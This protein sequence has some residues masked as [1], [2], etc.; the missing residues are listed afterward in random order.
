MNEYTGVI[1]RIFFKK[2]DF[3]IGLLETDTEEI[4][5]TGNI[6]GIGKNE[7]LTI[8]GEWVKHHKYGEQLQVKEWERPMPKTRE[9]VIS[10]LSSGLIKGVG[11][12]RAETIVD[13]LGEQAIDIINRDGEIALDGIKG[14]G[15]KTAKGIAESIKNTFEVQEIVSQLTV[16]GISTNTTLKLYR[17]YG[18]STAETVL[19]NPYVMTEVDGVGFLKADEIARKIG[20]MPTSGYRIN[21]C[22]DYVLK[23]T[24]NS[25]GHSYVYESELISETL[26][27]LNHNS[28][29]EVS[30]DEVMQG[31][32]AL[33]D[34]LLVIEEEKVYPKY[35]FEYELGLAQKLSK[36]RGSRDGEAMTSL[37]KHIKS[38]QKK[39]SIILADKQREAIKLLMKEQILIL[40]GGPGTGKT[41]VVKAMI[42]IYKKIYPK[43]I[44]RLAAPTGRASRKLEESTGYEAMTIHRMIGYRQ[45][46]LPEY[47]HD[48]RL[49]GDLIVIDEMSMVD[50][51]LAYWLINAVENKS[52]ILFIGDTDQLPS[53]GPGNVLKDM[54]KSGLPTVELTDI[55]R[56][57]E[58]SQIVTNAHRINSGK[59]LLIDQTK[60]DFYFINQEDVNQIAQLILLSAMRFEQLGYTT[61]DILILSPMKK[62]HVGT[63]ILNEKLRDVLNPK[64]IH[65]KELILGK[66][67][68]REGDKVM[69]NKNNMDKDVFNGELGRIKKITKEFDDNN[70]LID[71]IICDFDGS[72][73][74]YLREDM[75]EIELGYAITIHK[76][77]GGEA[78]IVIMPITTHHHVMLARNLY[79]TGVT[80]AKE[81][82]VLIGTNQAMDI[83][84]KNNQINKRNSQ[85]DKR[86][87][88]Y[89]RYLNRYNEKYVEH[90]HY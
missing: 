81:K 68:F 63:V 24:C 56:Q 2:D 59:P 54:I 19:R 77:Q 58:A 61:D 74:K 9:Q 66:R 83:A 13:K 71:V 30:N 23:R 90:S 10:F 79:Y 25:K 38:Y 49:A 39:N 67:M 51:Q 73:I 44:I 29:I 40:T 34:K 33:E 11:K 16:Y 27:A 41:T 89:T 6:Y 50:I 69:Q 70:K 43:S 48:N 37:D 86:I 60:N 62:G 47:H 22:I 1:T 76:S 78:P 17:E 7:D 75:N 36:M 26:L 80:R 45:G 64:S 3:I 84:I 8:K 21:A 42:D 85:L 32:Y 88:D 82:V 72:E 57:A 52:K 65:K 5:F 35:L 46:E 53:V 15:K 31:I 12:S 14:I 28:H 20:I 87:V 4:K 18:S 55:F